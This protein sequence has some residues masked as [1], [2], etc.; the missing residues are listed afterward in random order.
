[1][2]IGTGLV[3]YVTAVGHC[4]AFGGRCPSDRPP[5]LDDDVFRF[6]VFG[7]LI[8]I[9]PPI[10]LRQPGWRRAG[11]ALAIGLP[12]AVLIGFMARGVVAG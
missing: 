12:V 10:W 5:L 6:A 7:G 9:V 1:M 4:S 11:R 8:A 2:V 3:L